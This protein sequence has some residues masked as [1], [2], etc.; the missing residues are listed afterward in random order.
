MGAALDYPRHQPGGPGPGPH[1]PHGRQISLLPP[2]RLPEGVKK[3]AELTG[4]MPPDYRTEGDLKKGFV[5][6]RVPHVTLKA[7]ANNEEIDL[8]TPGGRRSWNPCARS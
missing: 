5:Y 8:S 2:G 6:K 4:Q 1:P 7:I 3:E